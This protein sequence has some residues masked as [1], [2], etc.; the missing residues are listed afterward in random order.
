MRCIFCKSDT[1]GSKSKEHI[2]PESLGNLDHVLPKGIVCDSC[3]NYFSRE[4]E[5]PFMELPGIGLLRANEALPSKKGIIPASTGILNGRHPARVQRQLSG[6]YSAMVGVP[7]EAF[8]ELLSRTGK[9]TLMLPMEGVIPEGS[10]VSRFMAKVAVE[11]L[12][13]RLLSRPELLEDFINDLA[14]E[15][16]RMHARRGSPPSWP[17]LRRRI[18]GSNQKWRHQ[19]SDNTQIVHE[20]DFIFLD[21]TTLYFVLA[22]FGMEYAINCGEPEVGKY[23]TWLTA[24]GGTSPLYYGKNERLAGYPVR[25]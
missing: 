20:S 12:A 1:T 6:P 17:V 21:H 10:V 24:N 19:G 25:V 3:N 9:F 5:K 4:V 16:L 2:I 22:L 23:E 14:L 15:P 7:S 8:Q 13:Q 18:Y 11:F